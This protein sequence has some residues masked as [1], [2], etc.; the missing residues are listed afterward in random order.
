MKHFIDGNYQRKPLC[1][2]T[3]LAEA[4]YTWDVWPECYSLYCCFCREAL[5]GKHGFF[6]IHLQNSHRFFKVSSLHVTNLSLTKLEILSLPL[7]S[8]MRI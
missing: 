1:R 3:G 4:A 7:L 2:K 6:H 5:N 8:C